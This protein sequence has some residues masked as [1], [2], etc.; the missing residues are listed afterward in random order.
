MVLG[1][2]QRMLADGKLY[3]DVAAARK[4]LARLEILQL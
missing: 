2:H 3:N 1:Y 4:L